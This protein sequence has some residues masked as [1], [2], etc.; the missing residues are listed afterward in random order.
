V[1]SL[2]LRPGALSGP[3]VRLGGG[4]VGSLARCHNDPERLADWRLLE[5]DAGGGVSGPLVR[6]L[7]RLGGIELEGDSLPQSGFDCPDVKGPLVRRE[8]WRELPMPDAPGEM[9]GNCPV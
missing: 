5:G 9:P 8:D 2:L 6:F 4:G 3:L 7:P 1:S